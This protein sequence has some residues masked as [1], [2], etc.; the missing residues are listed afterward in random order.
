MAWTAP[1]TWASAEVIV[2]SGSGSLNEQI[3]DNLLAL[4]GHTH[5]GSAGDGSS[6]LDASTSFSGIGTVTFSDQSSDPSVAGRLQRNST[7]LKFYDGSAVQNL[8]Q[9]DAAAATASLRSLGTSSTTA[10]A[11]DHT[12]TFVSVSENEYDTDIGT[13][14]ALSWQDPNKISD[15]AEITLITQSPTFS[16]TP[17]ARVIS[18]SWVGGHNDTS[19]TQ[20]VAL[21]LYINSVLKA[22]QTVVIPASSAS[23]AAH[24]AIPISVVFLEASATSGQQLDLKFQRTAYSSGSGDDIYT[25]GATLTNEIVRI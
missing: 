12:H 25:L 10:A 24:E 23:S 16:G 18:G 4:S 14:N 9:A 19:A 22:T 5:S 8:T 6:P 3:R 17:R 13:L 15:G 2:A 7:E 1:K 11:G 21:R 20:T